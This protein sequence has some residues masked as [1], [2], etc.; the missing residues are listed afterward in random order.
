MAAV[1]GNVRSWPWQRRPSPRRAAWYPTPDGTHASLDWMLGNTRNMDNPLRL[2]RGGMVN[3]RP[4]IKLPCK[5][6]LTFARGSNGK[7]MHVRCR[8]MAGTASEPSERF[9]VYD[10]IGQAGSIEEAK[11]MWK[12]A[13]HG[14]PC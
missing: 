5:I 3:A 10:P 14:Q 8:C 13:G 4:V 1:R 7:V 11:R 9:Y 2:P 12:D 6:V